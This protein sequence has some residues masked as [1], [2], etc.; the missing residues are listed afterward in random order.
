MG[1][2]ATTPATPVAEAEPVW[3]STYNGRASN[4]I[5]LPVR[6]SVCARKRA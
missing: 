5:M 2:V 3:S 4:V 6:E 1:R